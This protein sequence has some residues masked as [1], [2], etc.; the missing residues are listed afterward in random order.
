MDPVDSIRSILTQ[1]TADG[2]IITHTTPLDPRVQMMMKADFPF[3]SHGRTH[4]PTPHPYHDFHSEAFFAK[5]VDRLVSKGC[6]N[7]LLV[8]ETMARPITATSRRASWPRRPAS[9]RGVRSSLQPRPSSARLNCGAA[10]RNLFVRLTALTASSS[11]GLHAV[12]RIP[13]LKDGPEVLG[14]DIHVVYTQD[15]DLLP[16]L[17]HRSKA[18]RRTFLPLGPNWPACS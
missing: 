4:L 3:V 13:G 14:R 12:G 15:S 2:V 11:R 8:W 7:L 10:D 9:E 1:R 5:A 17:F 18:W 16:M 6:M